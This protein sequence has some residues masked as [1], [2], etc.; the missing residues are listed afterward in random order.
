MKVKEESE[1][2][3]LQLNI[4]GMQSHHSM[5]NRWGNNG[6]SIEISSRKLE[7]SMKHLM[8]EWAWYRTDMLR[9]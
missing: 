1:K 7:I 6:N 3:G 8:Q 2:V 4:Y 9:T 5:A